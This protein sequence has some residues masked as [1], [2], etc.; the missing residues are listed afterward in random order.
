MLKDGREIRYDKFKQRDASLKVNLFEGGQEDIEIRKVK[1]YYSFEEMEFLHCKPFIDHRIVLDPFT[2]N[3]QFMRRIVTGTI[4]V[5]QFEIQSGSTSVNPTTGTMNMGTNSKFLY[6]EKGNRFEVML[7]GTLVQ[8]KKKSEEILREMISDQPSVLAKV[9][10]DFIMKIDNITEVV[11][12]YN[13]MV[14][15]NQNRVTEKNCTLVVYRRDKKQ[16][17]K[18][19][20]IQLNDSTMLLGINEVISVKVTDE[21][22]NKICIGSITNCDLFEG[23]SFAPSYYELSYNKKGIYS[24]EQVSNKEG[25]YYVRMIE[26]IQ[27]R[28]N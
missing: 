28:S 27:K 3:Y 14:Y 7:P 24:L 23:F 1:G 22:L 13:L 11:R 18:P 10:E 19:V 4:N 16:V 6:I 9:D 12:T 25:E 15:N 5:Y 8:S 20:G 26:N 2:N 21:M 17:D